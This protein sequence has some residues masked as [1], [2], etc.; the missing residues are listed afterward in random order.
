MKSGLGGLTLSR[1]FGGTLPIGGIIPFQRLWE[2]T[3]DQVSNAGAVTI[4]AATT[5]VVA[6]T[7]AT[8]TSGNWLFI[9]IRILFTK[10][11]TLGDVQL[12]LDRNA[13]DTSNYDYLG[14][15]PPATVWQQ[16]IIA[17]DTPIVTG[18]WWCK[19]GATGTITPTLS[20][21]STG[22]NATVGIG[23]AVIRTITIVNT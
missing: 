13:G 22:S 23:G 1:I 17:N 4:T 3:L 5:V 10:G 21:Q 12:N 14:F 6:G 7:Q 16:S 11:A 18:D 2:T 20:A 19:V 9:S 8:H 15:V